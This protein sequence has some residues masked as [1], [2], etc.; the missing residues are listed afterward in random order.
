M[1]VEEALEIV[2]TVVEQG[3]L[4]KVQEIVFRH[5]WEKQSYTEIAVNSGYEV[6]Y[7]RD[8]GCRLW[9]S[10]SKAFGKKVTKNGVAQLRKIEDDYFLSQIGRYLICRGY[11]N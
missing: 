10:L 4:S 5:C 1:N 9:Q 8:V 6:G 11:Y 3:S 7:I 2:Q